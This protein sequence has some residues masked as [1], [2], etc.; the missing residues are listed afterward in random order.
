MS[1]TSTRQPKTYVNNTIVLTALLSESMDVNDPVDERVPVAEGDISAVAFLI[2]RPQDPPD[3]PVVLTGTVVED[4]K[5]QVTVPATDNDGPGQYLA[6]A[7]FLWGPSLGHDD[8]TTSVTCNYNVNDPFEDSGTQP[9][10]PAVDDAWGFFE[11]LFDSQ[12]EEG[13]P[14]LKEITS[15]RFDK[16]RVRKFAPQVMF[17]INTT[18]PQ[19]NYSLANFA[20]TQRDGNALFAQG[21][22]VHSIR[23]LIRSYA[24]QPDLVNS[25][26]GYANR[27]RYVDVWSGIYK[28][29][30]D[31]YKVMLDYYKRHLLDVGSK[32]LVSSKNGRGIF[33]GMR[34]RG[35]W[36]GYY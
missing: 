17:D 35:V 5:A 31:R 7:V 19:T 6:V 11:D 15:G 34:T 10:D 14:W 26:V 29:E 2:Q 21:L 1:F 23:H 28:M 3:T 13:G 27:Q 32:A 4:G 12:D 30:L 8:Y 22:L 9:Y 16:S 33:P 18:Q 20:Y 24:E 25:P 36:R